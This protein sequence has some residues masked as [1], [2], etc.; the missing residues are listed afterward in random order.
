MNRTQVD[1]DKPI[2]FFHI[3]HW[4]AGSQWI[5]KI[6]QQCAPERIITPKNNSAHF[7]EDPI[8]P[9]KVYPTVYITP[10]EFYSVKLP[11]KWQRFFIIRDLRD[12]LI[13][14][15]FSLKYSSV[16]IEKN[17]SARD[18]LNQLDSMEEGLA[19]LINNWLHKSANVQT[20]WFDI[21]EPFIRYENLLENDVEL[22][23]PHILPNL[24]ISKEKF[25]DAVLANRFEAFTK[26]RKKGNE[27]KSAHE[28]KAQHGD[29]KHHFNNRIKDLFK[30]KFGPVLIRAG[31]EKDNDW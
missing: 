18:T 30:E 9:G 3:T 8:L 25:H 10:Q 20:A 16:L 19:Y 17:K 24:N 14:R 5:Y 26:G 7:L 4:K 15:Y 28:R 12:T 21:N 6:L 13:S 1:D 29:W 11:D 22:L 27:D 2:T 31:Y 23:M